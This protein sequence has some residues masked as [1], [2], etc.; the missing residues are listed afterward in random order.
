MTLNETFLQEPSSRKG[1]RR[2]G[3][4]KGQFKRLETVEE[5][6]RS[7]WTLVENDRSAYNYRMKTL[8]A[9]VGCETLLDGGAGVNSVAEE[10]VVGA[11]NVAKAMGIG[12]KDARHPVV[13]LEKWSI[14]ECVTGISKGNDVPIIGAAVMRVR[15]PEVGKQ[16]GPEIVVRAKISRKV[17]AIG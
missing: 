16:T 17:R 4:G 9:N 2:K 1:G 8:I 3:G 11:L 7:C 15:L 10:I 6:P 13:Q 5:L 14:P 12:P